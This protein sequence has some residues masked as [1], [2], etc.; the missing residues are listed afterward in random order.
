[1]KNNQ[2]IGIVLFTSLIVLIIA[3]CFSEKEIEFMPAS[4]PGIQNNFKQAAMNTAYRGPSITSGAVQ[5]PELG[6]EVVLNR[7]GGLIVSR[8]Y[9]NSHAQKASLNPGDLIVRFNGQSYDSAD[10]VFRAFS[11]ASPETTVGISVLRNGSLQNLN[12]IIGKRELD[13]VIVPPDAAPVHR[14]AIPG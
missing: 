4:N 10:S 13:G 12:V 7:G 9:A 2:T 11:A 3:A 14:Y 1:M 6:M 5:V 8:V